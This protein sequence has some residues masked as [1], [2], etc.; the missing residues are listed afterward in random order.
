MSNEFYELDH[1]SK[2]KND[3]QTSKITF[4]MKKRK[5]F[6]SHLSYDGLKQKRYSN[7]ETNQPTMYILKENFFM[8][9]SS[10]DD[11]KQ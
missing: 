9:N 6:M 7:C 5:L 3:I 1:H 8:S 4:K 10:Y 11:L 2:T